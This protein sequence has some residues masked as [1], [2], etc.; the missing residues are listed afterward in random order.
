MISPSVSCP[1]V[2]EL[3]PEPYSNSCR[4][5]TESTIRLLS[6][7]QACPRSN[8]TTRSMMWKCSQSSER[9][10]SE[11]TTWKARANRLRSGQ[12]TRTSSTSGP[13]RS[14]TAAKPDGPSTC[15]ASTSPS[16][17][18]QDGAWASL[19]PSPAAQTTDPALQ[20]TQTSPSLVWNFS[21][22]GPSKVS[23]SLVK[24]A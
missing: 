1:T 24:N 5:R 12:T 4:L 9:W 17:T 14:S 3:Q 22:Y 23:L 2:L 7:P 20:T 21:K 18:S 8:A 6:S 10:K 13:P 15:P 11:D 16:T 19:T